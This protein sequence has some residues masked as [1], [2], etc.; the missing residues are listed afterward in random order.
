M[1]PH[2]TC[3]LVD[4]EKDAVELCGDISPSI[5]EIEEADVKLDS[6]VSY[7]L[8]VQD[9]EDQILLRGQLAVPIQFRCVRCG[10]FFEVGVQDDDFQV[11]MDYPDNSVSVDLTPQVREAIILNFPSYPLCR[12]DCKGLCADC[13]VN[14]NV[15]DCSCRPPED[16]R[17][18]ILNQLKS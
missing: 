13:G 7:D 14:L 5:L 17:W 11:L 16:D 1:K 9:V 3:R 15:S 2:I 6:P 12:E 8:L 4:L 10:E 18:Q